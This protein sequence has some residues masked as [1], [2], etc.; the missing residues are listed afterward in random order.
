MKKAAY[1]KAWWCPRTG[2]VHSAAAQ[3]LLPLAPVANFDVMSPRQEELSVKYSSQICAGLRADPVT[4][5]EIA[6][7]L[8]LAEMETH[9]V[10]ATV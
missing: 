7:A 5:L 10:A 1:I 8:Y 6:E 4:V 9:N 3:G 2:E